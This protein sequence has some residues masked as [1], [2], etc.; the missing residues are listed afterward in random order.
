[1][2]RLAAAP[3]GLLRIRGLVGWRRYA[4]ALG[5]GCLAALAFAPLRLWPLLIIAFSGLP[6]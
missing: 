6:C 2:T 4:V 5:F 1:M 3:E